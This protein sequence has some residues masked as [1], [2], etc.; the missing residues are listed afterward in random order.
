MSGSGP[1]PDTLL[2]PEGAADGY[3]LSDRDRP[4]QTARIFGYEEVMQPGRSFCSLLEN[5]TVDASIFISF[6]GV[7]WLSF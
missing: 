6:S 2:G 3:V 4:H 7:M 1:G 5:C